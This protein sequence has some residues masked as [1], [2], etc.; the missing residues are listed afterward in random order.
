ME[1]PVQFEDLLSIDIDSR[2]DDKPFFVKENAQFHA[3]E[4]IGYPVPGFAEQLPGLNIG[5]AKEFELEIP[6]KVL[7]LNFP[8]RWPVFKVKVNEIKERKTAG[9]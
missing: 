9:A 7:S 3:L 5:E 4:G 2:V 6:E 1:R 8:A